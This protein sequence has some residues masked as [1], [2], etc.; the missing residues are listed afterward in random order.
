M[1]F[2]ASLAYKKTHLLYTL[3]ATEMG[4]T[5]KLGFSSSSWEGQTII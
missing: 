2:R 5:Q 4:L 1:A 3:N